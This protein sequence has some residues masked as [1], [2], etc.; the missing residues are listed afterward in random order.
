MSSCYLEFAKKMCLKAKYIFELSKENYKMDYKFN[1]EI[2]TSLD[3]DIELAISDAIRKEFPT[4]SIFGEEFGKTY[5]SID[6]QWIIDPIDGTVNFT[7]G[8][9]FFS[10][11]LALKYKGKTIVGAI[12][13]YNLDKLYSAQEG[14]GCYINDVL[15]ENKERNHDHVTVSMLIPG[16]YNEELKNIS[17]DIMKAI[18]NHV[19]ETR[20]IICHSLEILYVALGK[21]DGVVCLGTRGISSSASLLFLT[22][23]G[24]Q[25][26]RTSIGNHNGLLVCHKKSYQI[27]KSILEKHGGKIEFK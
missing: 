17:F 25:F 13:D 9:P 11:S 27:I 24:K 4:H 18:S 22:E 20:M 3:K 2:V 10:F 26:Y 6:Y 8:I 14:N 23:S 12:Y 16:H 5:N 19:D 1:R 15:V 7:N 21:L